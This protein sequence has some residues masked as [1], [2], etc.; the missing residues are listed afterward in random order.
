MTVSYPFDGEIFPAKEKKFRETVFFVHFYDGSKQKLRR[1]I[2]MVNGFGYDAFAFNLETRFSLWR[3]PFSA[4]GSFG[5][6]HVY[7]DQIELLLNALP[8]PKI[9]Y[10]FSNPTGG[11]IEAMA[12]RHCSDTVALIADSGPSGKFL[13]SVYNLYEKEKR[14]SPAP[15]RWVLTPILTLAWSPALHSDLH[16]ELAEF[17]QDFPVLSIRGW[18]DELISPDQ[19]D[20]VF[21]PH[22][23]LDW[24]KLS[25]PEAGHLTGLRDFAAD[26]VPAVHRFLA[27]VSTPLDR[28]RAKV[29]P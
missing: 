11:A 17:P 26:Y 6:K 28:P 29:H 1:H 2:E 5:Y 25:L 7:A 19:I 27:Q 10:S 8:G 24:R 9:V 15:L 23:N 3:P 21:E 18:K 12:R 22:T 4:D 16:P 13:R 20:A 14:I